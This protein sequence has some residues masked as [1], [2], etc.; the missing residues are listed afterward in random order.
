MMR[1]EKPELES[2]YLVVEDVI[3]TSG[4]LGQGSDEGDV[5]QWPFTNGGTSF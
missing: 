1:Y 5:L 3:T 2:I 4:K